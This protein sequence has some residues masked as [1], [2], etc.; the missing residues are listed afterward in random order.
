MTTYLAPE[1]TRRLLGKAESQCFN[2][3]LLLARYIPREAIGKADV[4]DAR[5]KIVGKRDSEWLKNVAGRFK[6]DKV[7]PLVDAGYQRWQRRTADAPMRF[8]MP[9]ATRLIV[10]LGSKGA[11]E[12]GITLQFITGLP[13]IPGSALKGLARAYGLLSIAAALEPKLPEKELDKLDEALGKGE[14]ERISNP[15]L[16]SMAKHFQRA[17]GSQEAGGICIFYDS[18]VAKLPAGSLFETDVMTPHFSDYYSEK[19]QYPSDDQSP[20]P[21]TFLTIAPRTTFAFAVGLRRGAGTEDVQTAQ[22]AAAWLTTGLQELGIGSKTSAGY[23]A[24]GERQDL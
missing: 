23:G 13:I 18:V 12:I 14:F 17:F 20:I 22:Q 5:N 21:I 24:F 15:Q 16:L 3:S 6:A 10:G 9:A 4:R 19:T 7:K 1:S 8:T 2:L 11:L